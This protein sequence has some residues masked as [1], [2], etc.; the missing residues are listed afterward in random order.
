[1]RER[2]ALKGR[3]RESH[4]LEAGYR[5]RPKGDDWMSHAMEGGG[6]GIQ[7]FR[8]ALGSLKL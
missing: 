6:I 1:M 4:N 5:E 7:V 2:K 8:E 3:M